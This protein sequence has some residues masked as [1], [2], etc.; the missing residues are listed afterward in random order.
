M[1]E[2]HQCS[3]TEDTRRLTLYPEMLAMLQDIEGL[4]L[5]AYRQKDIQKLIA[6]C[7]GEEVA[8]A[9]KR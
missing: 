2:K 7:R 9:P 4:T 3:E 6:K 5:N 1:T 8:D